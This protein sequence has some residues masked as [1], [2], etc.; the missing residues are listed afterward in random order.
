MPDKT[1]VIMGIDPGIADTGYGVIEV[2]GGLLTALAFGSIR[3][4][5]GEPL[6]LRLRKLFDELTA[7]ITEHKPVRAGIESLFFANN[8]K[9]AFVVG[10]ARGVA[11]LALERAGVEVSEHT[12][13]QV[14]QAVATYGQAGKQQ[15]QRMVQTIL[16]LPAP[17][18]PDDAADALAVAIC[19]AN[20]SPLIR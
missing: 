9:T 12:P 7:L 20:S 15:I 2:K 10:Q 3:T 13:L 18:K 1:T 14:K 19:A 17:P 16:K 6:P 8:A 5:A 11:L 4:K